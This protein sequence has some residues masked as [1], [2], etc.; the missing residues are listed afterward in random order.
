[1]YLTNK[2]TIWYNNIITNAT[3]RVNQNGYFETHHIIPKSLGGTNDSS[4]LVKLTPKE[5]FICHRLLVKMT[6]G[7]E[8]RSMAYAAWQ[9]TLLNDRCRYKPNSRTYDILKK[10]LSESS[11]GIPMSEEHKAKMRKPKTAEHR[12]KLGQYERTAEHRSAISSMR[13]AQTGLQKRS[14]ETKQKMSEWQKGVAK[15]KVIC[16]HCSK[17][18]SQMN[19]A[20]WHGNNCKSYAKIF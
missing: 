20:R 5:H 15:P 11:K 1:M 16:E 19:Y 9:M 7:K 13:K 3:K 17:E 14:E 8:K 6:T 2:Y 10:Q 4:N 12:S 18:T